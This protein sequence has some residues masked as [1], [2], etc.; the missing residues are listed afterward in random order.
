MDPVFLEETANKLRLAGIL[1]KSATQSLVSYPLSCRPLENMSSAE[2]EEEK[3]Y[4]KNEPQGTRA[5]RFAPGM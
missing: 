2:R 5:E 3:A 4:F 1:C